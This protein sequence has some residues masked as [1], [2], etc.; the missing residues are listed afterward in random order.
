MAVREIRQNV[1]VDSVPYGESVIP[2]NRQKYLDWLCRRTLQYWPGNV[3]EVG[4]YR[5]GTLRILAE[6]VRSVCPDY[7]VYGIDTFSG[8]PYSDGHEVHPVGKYADTNPADVHLMLDQHGL[9][10]KWVRLVE[11]RVE[12]IFEGLL[13]G[14]V[15]PWGSHELYPPPVLKGVT[16]AHVDCDLHDAV[17]YCLENLRRAMGVHGVIF[18][19]DYGH[20]HCPGATEAVKRVFG[21]HDIHE[22]YLPCDDTCWSCYVQW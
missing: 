1:P 6:A 14:V 20:K 22:V 15:A 11:G 21:V 10:S 4:V 13:R 18:I 12:D 7:L 16:F 2:V 17:L 8:H 3:V 5:G 19:D 9:L